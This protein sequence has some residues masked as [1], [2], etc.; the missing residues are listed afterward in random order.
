MNEP[1]E[2]TDA[3][4]LQWEVETI[5]GLLKAGY[6]TTDEFRRMERDLKDS[7]TK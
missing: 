4:L 5:K 1:V 3:Q 6:I 2:L 7:I